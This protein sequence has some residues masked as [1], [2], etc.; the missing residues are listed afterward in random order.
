MKKFILIFTSIVFLGCSENQTPEYTEYQKHGFVCEPTGDYGYTFFA[1]YDGQKV[2]SYH[3]K[4]HLRDQGWSVSERRGKPVEYHF[5]NTE[6]ALTEWYI[7]K[8]KYDQYLSKRIIHEV[9]LNYLSPIEYKTR[10][11]IVEKYDD[12]DTKSLYTCLV[13]DIEKMNKFVA[14]RKNN[15]F[16]ES[17]GKFILNAIEGLNESRYKQ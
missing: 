7:P 6:D 2:Y 10:L 3:D 5:N 15:M 16:D 9:G 4:I 14:D 17:D 13:G 1:I 8:G 11:V 12:D